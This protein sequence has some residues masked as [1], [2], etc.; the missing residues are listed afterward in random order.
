MCM[1]ECLSVS[2]IE[3]IECLCVGA[4]DVCVCGSHD[5]YTKPQTLSNRIGV[6]F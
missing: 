2:T 6:R 1:L 4:L 3:W 5:I